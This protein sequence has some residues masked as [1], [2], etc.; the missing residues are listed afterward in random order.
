MT[1]PPANLSPAHSQIIPSE[2]GYIIAARL[3]P[4]D[5]TS[6]IAS[7]DFWYPP[8]IDFSDVT[9]SNSPAACRLSKQ[10]HLSI[11]GFQQSIWSSALQGKQVTSNNSCSISK[12]I[13]VPK[14]LEPPEC[15]KPN[16]L[17]WPIHLIRSNWYG[18]GG[19]PLARE[20]V[21]PASGSSPMPPV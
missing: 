7:G 17:D 13:K 4:V 18:T 10:Q 20:A 21:E 16:H 9:F 11:L 19:L 2:M 6:V 8:S 5:V 3:R 15:L 1:P 14:C 12:S